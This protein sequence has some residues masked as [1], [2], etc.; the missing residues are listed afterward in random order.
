MPE[1]EV[2]PWDD[3]PEEEE[4]AEPVAKG[5]KARAPKAKA[6][7]PEKLAQDVF[8]MINDL[9][10]ELKNAPDLKKGDRWRFT[11]ESAYVRF[12]G[13]MGSVMVRWDADNLQDAAAEVLRAAFPDGTC[14][15]V[16]PADLFLWQKNHRILIT[17]VEADSGLRFGT[18]VPGLE[19]FMAISPLPSP[20]AIEEIVSDESDEWSEYEMGA[21]LAEEAI[22]SRSVLTLGFMD[23]RVV[24]EYADGHPGIRITPEHLVGFA[25]AESVWA[26]VL[27]QDSIDLV[28]LNARRKGMVYVTALKAVAY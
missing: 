11:P 12:G 6:G 19:F 14:S 26:E 15:F 20:D 27:R 24:P 8:K 23:G 18:S 13:Q 28:R 9:N 3:Q 2:M 7:S 5:K 25:K 21:D 16:S 1:D 22:A 10:Q 17:S 4:E